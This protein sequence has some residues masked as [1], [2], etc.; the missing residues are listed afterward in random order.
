MLRIQSF[1]LLTV[2]LVCTFKLEKLKH[3]KKKRLRLI[4]VATSL[5][6]AK[7]RAGTVS[8]V[9]LGVGVDLVLQGGPPGLGGR[10][11]LVG[12]VVG[13]LLPEVV[14]LEAL[15]AAG[16]VEPLVAQVV[17]L[18]YEHAQ[19]AALDLWAQHYGVTVSEKLSYNLD[20]LSKEDQGE[21]SHRHRAAGL[22]WQT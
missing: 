20:F 16:V 21:V 13:G 6:L 7:N 22:P 10:V 8:V 1:D 12:L 18:G 11:G 15:L 2:T 17:V 9:V 3:E 19:L 4:K 14:V 5:A